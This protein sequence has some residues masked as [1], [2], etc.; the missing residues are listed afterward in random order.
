MAVTILNFGVRDG[1]GRHVASFLVASD[2][3]NYAGRQLDQFGVRYECYVIDMGVTFTT[4]AG[5]YAAEIS[6]RF[7]RAAEIAESAKPGV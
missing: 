4:V 1:E 3:L 6:E 2:A 7:D 5:A